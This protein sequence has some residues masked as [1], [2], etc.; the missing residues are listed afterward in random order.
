MLVSVLLDAYLKWLPESA[1]GEVSLI[2]PP[3]DYEKT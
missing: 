2:W 3:S 1:H